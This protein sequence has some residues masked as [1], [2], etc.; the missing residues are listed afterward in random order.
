MR[1]CPHKLCLLV[2]ITPNQVAD[3]IKETNLIQRPGEAFPS[4]VR[5]SL[6][7]KSQSCFSSLDWILSL[8]AEL[9]YRRCNGAR[10]CLQQIRNGAFV[11]LV[12]D[13]LLKGLRDLL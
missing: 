2:E 13:F 5:V 11:S 12:Q 7:L 4:D 8:G 9:N 3:I 10:W 1:P 6:T